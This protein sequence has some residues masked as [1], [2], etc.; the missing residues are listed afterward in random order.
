[1]TIHL[2]ALDKHIMFPIMSTAAGL[3]SLPSKALL[4]LMS[5]RPTS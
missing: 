4:A 1:M 2:Q 5:L 3:Y